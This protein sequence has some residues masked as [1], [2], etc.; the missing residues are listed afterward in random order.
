MGEG[1]EVLN[2]CGSHTGDADAR[3]FWMSSHHAA[4]ARFDAPQ[5]MMRCNHVPD[6]LWTYEVRGVSGDGIT[7]ASRKGSAERH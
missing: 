7:D 5:T 1:K 2:R 6:D 4:R 3:F